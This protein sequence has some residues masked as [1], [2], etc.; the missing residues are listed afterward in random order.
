MK[1]HETKYHDDDWL[2]ASQVAEVLSE[3]SPSPVSLANV[4]SVIRSRIAAGHEIHVEIISSKM[5]RYR[6][7]DIKNM[8]VSRSRNAGRP[9]KYDDDISPVAIRQ[10]RRRARLASAASVGAVVPGGE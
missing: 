3:N 9:K 2:L 6:Y 4:S 5:K 7:G 10:R 8:V 1:A